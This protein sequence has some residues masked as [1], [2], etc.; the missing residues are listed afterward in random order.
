MNNCHQV[1]PRLRQERFGLAQQVVDELLRSRLKAQEEDLQNSWKNGLKTSQKLENTSKQ[2]R[3]IS[4]KMGG[5]P[6]ELGETPWN[7][8]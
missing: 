8:R 4:K 6:Q 2:I 7:Y 3:K 1:P 5:D